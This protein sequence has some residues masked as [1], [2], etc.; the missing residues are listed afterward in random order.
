MQKG[1]GTYE[2]LRSTTKYIHKRR[3]IW[4]ARVREGKA[5]LYRTLKYLYTTEMIKQ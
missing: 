1:L 5:V 4:T 2:C 3:R